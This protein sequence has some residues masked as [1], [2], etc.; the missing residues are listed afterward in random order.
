MLVSRGIP[1]IS[2]LPIPS[3]FYKEFFNMTSKLTTICSFAAALLLPIA[4][5]AADT[6]D[7]TSKTENAKEFVNDATIT[8]KVKAEFAKEKGVSATHIKVDTDH[9]VVKLSGDAKS[10]EEADKAAAI[11]QGTKGVVSVDNEIQVN[12]SNR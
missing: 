4:G 5:Y 12:P 10:Q 6:T 3:N 7:S 2:I 1:W 11:A 8:T 9:G